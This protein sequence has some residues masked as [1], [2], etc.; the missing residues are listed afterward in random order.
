LPITSATLFSA[1]DQA[2][3]AAKGA[4]ESLAAET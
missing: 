4:S 3:E 1:I 2:S